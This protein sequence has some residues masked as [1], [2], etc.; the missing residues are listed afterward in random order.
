MLGFCPF[1]TYYVR[2]AQSQ[3]VYKAHFS[4]FLPMNFGLSCDLGVSLLQYLS[5]LKSLKLPNEVKNIKNGKTHVAPPKTKIR[6][7]SLARNRH[8]SQ[9]TLKKKRKKKKN[10]ETLKKYPDALA[11]GL[12]FKN[13]RVSI[14]LQTMCNKNVIKSLTLKGCF[15]RER[16]PR[17]SR[18]TFLVP[19]SGEVQW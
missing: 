14:M 6:T 9:S 7:V 2:E 4:R 11:K 5:I 17:F 13:I 3:I 10:T 19:G 1:K 18:E 15:L 12:I 8:I 16:G